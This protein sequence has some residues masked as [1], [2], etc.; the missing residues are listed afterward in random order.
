M[1]GE[2]EKIRALVDRSAVGYFLLTNVS[3][4]SHLDVGSIDKLNA[5]LTEQLDLPTMCWWRDDLE[6]RLDSAWSIKWAY[7]EIMTGPDFLR[8]I[9]ETGVGAEVARR[10]ST[11]RAFLSDQYV[12]DSQVRFRQ[13]GLETGLLDLFIDVPI[14]LSKVSPGTHVYE[15]EFNQIC[16]LI[17]SAGADPADLQTSFLGPEIELENTGTN[18]QSVGAASFLLTGS[19]YSAV[20]H[21]VLEGAPGQGKS[22]ISQYL[23]QVHRIRLLKQESDL[24]KLPHTHRTAPIRLPIRADIRDFAVWMNRIDPFSSNTREPLTL[25]EPQQLEPFLAALISHHAGGAVFGVDDLIAIF[26]VSSVSVVLDGLDEIAEIETREAVINEIVAGTHRLNAN[27][28]SLQVIVTSRPP[29]FSNSPGMPESKFRYVS[30]KS[31]SMTLIARYIER[32]GAARAVGPIVQGELREFLRSKLRQPHVRELARNPMQLAILLSL[33]HSRGPALPEKRTALYEAYTDH[34]FAREAEKSPTVRAHRGL[35]MD[36]HQYL[37]WTLH[38]QVE[39]SGGRGSLSQEDLI[40]LVKKYLVLEGHDPS[41][42]DRLFSGMVERVLMLVSRATGSFEFEVQPLREYFAARYLFETAPLSEP[43]NERRGAR[44]DRFDAIARSS[45]WLNV[46]RF[47]AGCYSKGEIP[48]LVNSLRELCD[49]EALGLVNQPRRLAASLLSDWVFAQIP[50][51]VTEVVDLI[52]G[53]ESFFRFI[54]SARYEHSDGVA[55]SLRLSQDC[56]Q[57]QLISKCFAWLE[58]EIPWDYAWWVLQI[59]QTNIDCDQVK[60]TWYD[61]AKEKKDAKFNKWLHYGRTIGAL[62]SLSVGEI[63]ELLPIDASREHVVELYWANRSDFLN[64]NEVYFDLALSLVLGDQMGAIPKFEASGALEMVAWGLSGQMYS[65][66]LGQ[67]QPISMKEAL[68]DLPFVV[69][70]PPDNFLLPALDREA[71]EKFS[72]FKAV[73]EKQ[74][75][76]PVKDWGT[77]LDPWTNIT[78]ASI[79]LWGD[80]RAARQLAIVAGAARV[81]GRASGS[82]SDLFSDTS[83]CHRARYARLAGDDADY[84]LLHFASASTT[85][86]RL[87]VLGAWLAYGSSKTILGSVEAASTVMDALPSEPWQW[88][89]DRLRNNS[90]VFARRDRLDIRCFEISPESVGFRAACVVAQLANENVRSSVIQK[91]LADR[92]DGDALLQTQRMWMAMDAENIGKRKWKPNLPDISD[93]YLRGGNVQELGFYARI[94]QARNIHIRREVAKPILSEPLKYPAQ[95]VQLVEI[96]YR[97]L[98]NRTSTPVAATAK[99]QGWFAQK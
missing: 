90:Y 34:F 92:V 87:F 19:K 79:S 91:L 36:L 43:G 31:L 66:V 56:G 38:A 54:A 25:T 20:R 7:P 8:A 33:V 41:L 49:D 21:L 96:A 84:W 47:Y 26:K 82:Y 2:I 58:K 55:Q 17:Q 85:E 86:D 57:T 12:K 64:T 99:V 32:W 44:P 46:A 3:G 51:S 71:S 14:G 72:V 98:L 78:Q 97:Q 30:L 83:L 5:L 48:S 40:V 11:I 52:A 67:R 23:C 80:S 9:I 6:R 74:L 1:A 69:L 62:G 28:A 59:L 4:S 37:A 24:Q 39:T 77:S 81:G 16:G 88:F 45:Y 89:S 42:A 70:P 93:A 27:A 76:L 75:E 61:R 60:K 65:Y 29:A 53:D 68:R 94:K 18:H 10:D 50:R 22:T 95:M 35:L 15:T 13:V 73:L 63:A